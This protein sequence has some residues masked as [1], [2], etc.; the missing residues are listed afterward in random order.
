MKSVKNI[1][2][3]TKNLSSILVGLVFIFSGFVK[4]IDLLGSTY[5]FSDYF[6]A[7]GMPSLESL[8][9]PMAFLLSAVEFVIG[10][11]L[12]FRVR[13]RF[14]S[15]LSLLFMIFFTLL[16]LYI[17][18]ANPVTDCGC[19]GDAFVISNWATFWK[20]VILILL[21]GNVFILRNSFRKFFPEPLLEWGLMAG[22][23]LFFSLVSLY[24]YKHLPVLDFRPYHI[25]SNI[26]D[27]MNI[28]PDAP[29]D[30]YKITLVYEK[31]GAKKEFTMDNL[32]DSTWNW[33][34]TKSVLVKKGYEP[35]IK[36]FMIETTYE[37]DDM[38][39]FILS[40]EG[41]TFLVISHDLNI[42]QTKNQEKINKLGEYARH[43]H[44]QFYCLTA[45]PVSLIEEFSA[46]HN[47]HYEFLNVD[48]ITLKTMVR[49]NPGLV[50]MN[51]GTIIGKWHNNDI[52]EVSDLGDNAFAWVLDQLRI[53]HERTRKSFYIFLFLFVVSMVW[54]IR[55]TIK[56]ELK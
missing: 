55:K 54:N 32:P 51:N 45:S 16:T 22:M 46:K 42:A 37:R 36:N 11:A 23:L 13:M 10:A 2:N 35:P 43:Y 52:P 1:L 56:S 6:M 18:I 9:L 24:S 14:F 40:Y 53:S 47:A 4:G 7:F 30:E 21:V 38:T 33:V 28:P 50:V 15:W 19:F 29:M 27:K 49:S 17:A 20:N 8:S 34:E 41:L 31:D 48:E 44:H 5:K 3:Y 26:Y 12:L 25:G 39:D